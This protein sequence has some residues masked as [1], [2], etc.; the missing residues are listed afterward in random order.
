MNV[1]AEGAPEEMKWCLSFRETEKP[2]VLNSTNAQII[3]LITGQEITEKW[4]GSRLVLYDDPNIQFGGKLTGGIRARAPRNPGTAGAPAFA[5]QPD[6]PKPVGAFLAA[7]IP[8]EPEA[9]DVPF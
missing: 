5:P 7:A 3:A 4:T 9:E 6:D 2:M 1:A 8:T